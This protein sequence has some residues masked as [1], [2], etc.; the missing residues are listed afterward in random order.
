M[1]LILLTLV[2]LLT[3]VQASP[4]PILKDSINWCSVNLDY[5]EWEEFKSG[6][7]AYRDG[8]GDTWPKVKA[9][10]V[11]M[12]AQ[13]KKEY[14][15]SDDWQIWRKDLFDIIF[16]NLTDDETSELCEC[17]YKIYGFYPPGCPGDYQPPW[18]PLPVEKEKCPQE[19]MPPIAT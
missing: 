13:S 14:G 15:A 16:S 3:A 2:S 18:G 8:H 9:K 7:I 10:A 5:Q 11:G 19:K 6:L 12:Y 17:L 1:L 4:V